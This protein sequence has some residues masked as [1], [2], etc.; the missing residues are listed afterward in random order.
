MVFGSPAA[1]AHRKACCS[2]EVVGQAVEVDQH[3]AVSQVRIRGQGHKRA[4]RAA[5]HRSCNVQVTR[6][7]TACV[8]SPFC[9]GSPNIVF[10]S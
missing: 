9:H 6:H 2:E 7:R 5:T 3:I 1:G 4:L 10:V 8:M